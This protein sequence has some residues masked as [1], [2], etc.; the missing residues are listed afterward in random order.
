[1]F[2]K[3]KYIILALIIAFSSLFTWFFLYNDFPHP[4]PVRATQVFNM[5]GSVSTTYPPESVVFDS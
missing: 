5:M 1:M 2:G 4:S 3:K